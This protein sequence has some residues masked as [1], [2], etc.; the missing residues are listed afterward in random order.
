M[1]LKRQNIEKFWPVPR[2]GTKYLAVSAHDKKVSIP[3]VVVMRDILKFVNN[4]K[5]LKKIID[6]KKVLINNKAIKDIHYPVNIFDIIS[7]PSMNK[8]FK[9]ILSH[10]KMIFEEVSE[11]NAEKMTFKV[12]SKKKLKKNILQINLSH[13]R[14]ILTKEK[15]NV[16]DSVIFNSKKN[17]IEKIIKMEKG[18]KAYVI[19]GKHIGSSGKI[20]NIF[21]RG[22]KKLTKI[23]LPDKKINVWIKNVI[24]MED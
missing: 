21:E 8:H 22:G 17:T 23:S 4:K 5:E 9:A 12:I 16:D 19:K 3:L 18:K 11:K 20:E 1:Y 15:V 13:G 2:K 24:A 14:N 7:L 10:K 6:E